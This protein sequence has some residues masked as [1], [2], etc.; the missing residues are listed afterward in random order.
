MKQSPSIWKLYILLKSLGE[1]AW[2]KKSVI[3]W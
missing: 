3:T 2:W 1:S